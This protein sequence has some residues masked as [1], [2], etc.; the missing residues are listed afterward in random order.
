LEAATKFEASHD[1]KLYATAKQ[2]MESAANYYLKAGDEKASTWVTANEALLD[3]YVYMSKAETEIAHDER[4]RQYQLAE[5]HLERS[6]Q[7][8]EKAGYTGKRDVTLKALAKVKEKREFA[9]SLDE[10]IKPPTIASS[11]IVFS[12]PPPTKEEA[13]GLERFEHANIQAYLSAPEETTLGEEFEVRMDLANVAKENGLLVR[14]EELIPAGFEVAKEP[15]PYSMDGRSLNAKGKQLAPQKVESLTLSLKSTQTGNF[16]LCPQVIYV[17][18]LGKFRQFRCEPVQISVLPPT[19]F[20]FTTNNAQLVF[21]HLTKAFIEDYMKR[22]LPLEKSGWRTL[23]Q[24]QTDAKVPKSSLYGTDR[25]RGLA[26][27]ELERRGLIETRIYPGE[28]G[29]GGKILKTRVAY[30][31]ETIKRYIDHHIMKNKEK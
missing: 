18:E 23:T 15:V 21:E 25:H 7:L 10:A 3:A 6:A 20:Q 27:S 11:T 19:G 26:I 5:K 30:D 8:Y 14:I 12:A 4:I 9:L 17:D 2:N 13:V 1:L 29:R 31:K 22:R 16:Q 24:I 28:R